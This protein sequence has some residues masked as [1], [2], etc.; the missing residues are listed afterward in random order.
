MSNFFTW[1]LVVHFGI[2]LLVDVTPHTN[3]GN[4]LCN[5]IF[6]VYWDMSSAYDNYLLRTFL[7]YLEYLNSSKLNDFNCVESISLN[8]I[9][10]SS[11]NKPFYM[12]LYH[13]CTPTCDMSL[14]R[15]SFYSQRWK[16]KLKVC[17]VIS[18]WYIQIL[19]HQSL[20]LIMSMFMESFFC[21]KKCEFPREKFIVHMLPKMIHF[22]LWKKIVMF[23]L[24]LFF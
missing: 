11:C 16:D 12:I 10:C 6:L 24:L 1:C 9:R 22:L 2:T 8:T 3:I 14:C 18:L 5:V 19:L 7:P 20:K 23:F 17:I 4:P 15:W 21:H 13:N